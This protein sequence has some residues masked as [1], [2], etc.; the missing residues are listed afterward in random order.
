MSFKTVKYC[1]FKAFRMK[2]QSYYMN[3]K[4]NEVEKSTWRSVSYE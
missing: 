4:Q 1:D 3:Y 2:F